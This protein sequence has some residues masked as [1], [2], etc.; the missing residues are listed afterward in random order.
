MHLL[1]T[2][3]VRES[4][5]GENL[6]EINIIALL[7]RFKNVIA[8]HFATMVHV[9]VMVPVCALKGIMDMTVHREHV[10]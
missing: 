6:Q 9:M 1:C 4:L 2:H 7:Q 10:S 5:V 8:T 3:S